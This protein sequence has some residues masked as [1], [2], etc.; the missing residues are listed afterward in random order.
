MST[1]RTVVHKYQTTARRELDENDL[2]R[3]IAAS[4]LLQAVEDWV[5]CIGMEAMLD[6]GET[7]KRIEDFRQRRVGNSNLTELRKFFRSDY[8][9]TLCGVLSL[10]AETVLE[11]LEGWLNDYHRTGVVPK[12]IIPARLLSGRKP[13]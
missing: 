3:H 7:G 5:G 10:D 2:I 13:T 12:G 11:K 8:G 4:I 9:D 1:P 6:S